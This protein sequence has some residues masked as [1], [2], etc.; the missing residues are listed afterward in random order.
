MALRT[1]VV[2]FSVSF[3][4]ILCWDFLSVITYFR[5]PAAVGAFLITKAQLKRKSAAGRLRDQL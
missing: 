5:S 3:V 4:L 1:A 2:C